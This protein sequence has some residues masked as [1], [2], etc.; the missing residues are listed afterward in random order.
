M[1][2]ILVLCLALAVCA[3]AMNLPVP[4]DVYVRN[5]GL[6]LPQKL[7]TGRW[8]NPTRNSTFIVGGSAAAAGEIPWI[9]SL[10]TTSHFCGGSI[11]TSRTVL[12]A[13]HCL[14]G[15]TASRLKVRVGSLQHAGG[16]TQLS[17]TQIKIHNQYNPSTIDYDVGLV[18]TSTAIPIG[19]NVAT[20]SLAS[21]DPAN[22][23]AVVA[24][25]WGTTSQG[26]GTL[27]ANLLK[28]TVNVIAR[29]TCQSA[30]GSSSITARMICAGVTGGGKDSC[31]G[32]SGG[33]LTSGNQQVGIVSWGR[34][35]AQAAYPGVYSSVSALL[36]WITSNQV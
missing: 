12:T 11:I 5:G 15:Q 26:S 9:A 6:P 22:G 7:R 23:A 13:A 16:G 27:P 3:T 29:A 33:P 21:S 19:G 1:K 14:D 28:V 8:Y 10:S 20:V 34:G 35:C 17:V 2:T 18:I 31:Q 25:G 36:S 30:Y 32:D 4:Y 24:A